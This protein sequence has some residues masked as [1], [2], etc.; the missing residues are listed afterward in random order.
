MIGKKAIL[1]DSEELEAFFVVVV[2]VV[3]PFV[4]VVSVFIPTSQSPV[5]S[6]VLSEN[7][8]SSV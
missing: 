1:K 8:C 4:V 7:V 5:S 6:T 2:V 3:S